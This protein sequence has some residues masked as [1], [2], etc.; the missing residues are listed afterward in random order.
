MRIVIVFIPSYPSYLL[1]LLFLSNF[2]LKGYAAAENATP[3]PQQPLDTLKT[4]QS[5]DV[6]KDP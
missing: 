3:L 5:L 1:E 4:Q 2:S 6:L